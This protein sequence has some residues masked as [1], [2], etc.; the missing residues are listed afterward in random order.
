MGSLSSTISVT[1]RVPMPGASAASSRACLPSECRCVDKIPFVKSSSRVSIAAPAPSPKITE[2]LRPRVDLSI[3]CDCNS[4]PI[5]SIFLYIPVLINWSATEIE[6][7]NP[8]HC[9]LISNAATVPISKA[10]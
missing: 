9:A 3:P 1:Q 7:T 8:E 2:I 6:Y 5:T 10:S 4:L